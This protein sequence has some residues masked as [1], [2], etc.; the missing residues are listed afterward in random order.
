M[1]KNQVQQSVS[2][3]QKSINFSMKEIKKLLKERKKGYPDKSLKIVHDRKNN[4]VH[5]IFKAKHLLET[6][7]IVDEFYLKELF[8]NIIMSSWFIEK[9]M[10]GI[11]LYPESG[12]KGKRKK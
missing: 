1:K 12:E 10:D 2:E 6:E 5:F 8:E 9:K 4:N 3:T 7:Y 11:Q